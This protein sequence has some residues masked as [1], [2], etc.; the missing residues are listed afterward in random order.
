MDFDYHA[1]WKAAMETIHILREQNRE[2]R[3]FQA[4]AIRS[5]PDISKLIEANK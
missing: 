5:V 2:L 4:E 3:Q 1:S